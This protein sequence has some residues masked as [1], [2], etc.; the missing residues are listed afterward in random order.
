VTDIAAAADYLNDHFEAPKLLI[1]HSLGGAAV[2]QAAKQIP[3]CK[4]IATIAAPADPSDLSGMLISSEEEIRER[5]EVEVKIAGRSFRVNQTFLEELEEV[6]MEESIQQ[7]DPA[8]LVLHSS[9]DQVVPV[10]NAEKIF[11][12]AGHPKGFI[13]LDEADHLLTD[14]KDGRYAGH[15]LAAWAGRYIGLSEEA[16]KDVDPADNRVRV[17][18][19]KTGFQT[20][21][22]ANRHRLI[23]DEPVPSGGADSGPTPYDYLVAALGSCTGMTLRM[24]ADQ[25]KW[26]LDEVTV[27][28]K[29]SKI[30]ADDCRSCETKEGK[31]D[32]IEREIEPIGSLSEEQRKKLLE[33]A[34][35]CPVHRT[36]HSEIMT[37][38][39]LKE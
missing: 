22:I 10:R 35:K 1:G 9:Q 11:A 7:L 32:R 17:S 26:P 14:K 2:I 12:A 21:I 20:E 37:E 36:L 19:G 29:H 18:T 30:H 33:I 8:L 28:L 34:D 16:P 13:S 24:Y 38:S 4:A 25:K 15:V 5:G 3:S 27:R 31:I 23:A 39:T 6:K